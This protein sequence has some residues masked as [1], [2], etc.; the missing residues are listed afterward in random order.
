M[1]GKLHLSRII[2]RL[3]TMLYA[4]I[5]PLIT[6]EDVL[7]IYPVQMPIMISSKMHIWVG[8]YL[9]ALSKPPRSDRSLGFR[10]Y[11]HKCREFR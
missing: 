11:V 3:L 10:V 6:D 4:D 7:V 2:S 1:M 8:E 9:I 5:F